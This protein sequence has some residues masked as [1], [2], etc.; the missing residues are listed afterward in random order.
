MDFWLSI[1]SELPRESLGK[2]LYNMIYDVL[3]LELN[4]YEAEVKDWS[5]TQ[6]VS[7]GCTY[8]TISINLDD[9]DEYI[10]RYR[11]LNLET[12]GVDTNVDISIQFISRTF[13]TGWLKFLELIG[14][15][16]QF[17]SQDLV[18]EDDSSY[19]LLKR[20]DGCLFINSRLDEYRTW[21]MTKENLEL[22]NYPYL[23]EDFFKDSEFR[24]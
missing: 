12:H 22:L 13:D 7:I 9:E 8:F 19:P 3:V 6:C 21:Y 17:N 16:L 10:E 4:I 1:G 2:L 20:I 5:N 15:L 11:K 23:E 14:K 24:K 18:V